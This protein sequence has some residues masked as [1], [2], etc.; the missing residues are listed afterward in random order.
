MRHLLCALL[1]SMS[2]EPCALF[3]HGKPEKTDNTQRSESA[4]DM[5]KQLYSAAKSRADKIRI[6]EGRESSMSPVDMLAL[7]VDYAKDKVENPP[8][9]IIE[10]NL[11]RLNRNIRRIARELKRVS[12][13]N[14]DGN[15]M[16]RGCDDVIEDSVLD[17]VQG[18]RYTIIAKRND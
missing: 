4:V 3:L 17:P 12:A 2:V 11:I 6:Q 8:M 7:A 18:K 1:V 5:L 16:C 15:S 14:Q 13:G 10:R 9:L